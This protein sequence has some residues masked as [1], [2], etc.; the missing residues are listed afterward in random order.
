MYTCIN[1]ESTIFTCQP[2]PGKEWVSMLFGEDSIDVGG[3]L[4]VHELCTHT[5]TPEASWNAP[6]IYNLRCIPEALYFRGIKSAYDYINSPIIIIMYK[7]F[8]E[9]CHVV[10]WFQLGWL[11]LDAKWS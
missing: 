9:L 4:A 6:S 7:Y 5:H 2:T 10:H 8:A 3:E 11:R 1:D